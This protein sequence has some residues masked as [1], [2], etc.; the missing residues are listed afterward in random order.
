MLVLSEAVL[1]IV[2]D[3]SIGETWMASSDEH[4]RNIDGT[5]RRSIV[6]DVSIGETWM[7]SSD[8]H[9]RNMDGTIRR[10]GKRCQHWRN[11]DG[12]IRRAL[13]K[14]G[15]HHPTIRG[16]HYPTIRR[17]WMAPSDDPL[18]GTIRRSDPTIRWMA[19]SDD[20]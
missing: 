18:D 10:S 1:V 20:P 16:W 5:I 17:S 9:W 15:W 2:S 14:H 4:W 19:P 13:A 7:A 3:V 12:I 6:S 11:M 8:E